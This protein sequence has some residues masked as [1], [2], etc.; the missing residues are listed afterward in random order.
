[1]KTFHKLAKATLYAVYLLILVG[2]IVRSTGS[3][4]GCPD[5]PTCFGQWIPPTTVT[6]LPADYKEQYAEYRNK[7]NIRFAKYLSAIGFEKEATAILS[8]PEVLVEEDFNA[9]KTWVEYVNRL[10]GVIIGL[11]IFAVMVYSFRFRKWHPAITVVG[12]LTFLLVGFQGWIGSFVVS[13][14][15]T[16]WTITVHMLLAL[17]IVCLLVYLVSA[18]SDHFEI[19]ISWKPL[20]VLLVFAL[21]LLLIQ[22]TIGTQ[23]R[24]AIDV[25]ASSFK[26]N[27]WVENLGLVF[28]I[29]RSFS[30]LLVITFGWMG[31]KVWKERKA[32]KSFAYVVPVFLLLTI[33]S[34]IGMAYA[35]VPPFLQPLHLTTATITFGTVFLLLLRSN[36]SK[37]KAFNQ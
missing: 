27:Q 32:L 12:I 8:D 30:W 31:Y 9:I 23:V 20:N 18:S 13:T 26:R 19:N 17:I 16:P 29:H 3:G 5:W 35:G 34:G 33:F 28:L 1:M 25:V 7:K 24:E 21:V 36:R 14:N 37:S 15:L 6:E 22:I 4:M 10:V 2:G 11:L